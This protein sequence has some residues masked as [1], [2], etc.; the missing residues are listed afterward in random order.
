MRTLER[1]ADGLASVPLVQ[2]WTSGANLKRNRAVAALAAVVRATKVGRRHDEGFPFPA[3]N[4]DPFKEA[5]KG[6]S[7]QVSLCVDC[8]DVA[9]A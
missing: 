1:R 5:K 6:V 4:S 2:N 7:L 3:I 8:C 9:Q